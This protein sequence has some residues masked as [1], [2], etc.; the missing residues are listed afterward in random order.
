MEE[1]K[2][3]TFFSRWFQSTSGSTPSSGESSCPMK[4]GDKSLNPQNLMPDDDRQKP[5]PGQKRPL[6]TYRV[7]SDIPKGEFTPN[8]QKDGENTDAE[9]NTWWY[10]SEQQF[11]SA[12]KRKGME[13]NEEDM[14]VVV[15]IH[16]HVNDTAWEKI[17]EY[18]KLHCDEC[19]APKLLK[20]KGRPKELSPKATFRSWL[21]YTRPFDRHDWTVDR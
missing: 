20:F 19:E 17:L 2:P 9:D 1:E 10:P 21:G 15:A 3:R 13:A 4:R 11:Y 8:H 12:L 16:N 7:K 18:E 6:S 14:K 5:F